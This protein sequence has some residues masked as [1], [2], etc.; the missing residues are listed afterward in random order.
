MD[1]KLAP[2][3]AFEKDYLEDSERRLPH[4]AGK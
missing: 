2:Q 3:R 1:R 4:K